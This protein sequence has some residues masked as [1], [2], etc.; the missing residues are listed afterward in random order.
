[1]SIKCPVGSSF[2]V[3]FD[4]PITALY[5]K[6]QTS[7]GGLRLYSGS[8][9]LGIIT[10]GPIGVVSTI[11]FNRIQLSNGE[12]NSYLWNLEWAPPIP[13]PGALAL[14]GIGSLGRGGRRR[15]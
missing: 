1:M 14:L 15:R 10:D 5:W 4:Q 3:T 9:Y 11:P 7:F 6:V 13:A 2:W 8:T 12:L